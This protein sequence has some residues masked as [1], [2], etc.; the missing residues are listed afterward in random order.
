LAG[1]LL[2]LSA[3]PAVAQSAAAVREAIRQAAQDDGFGKQVL[4]LTGFAALP[5]VNASSFS[6]SNT[7]ASDVDVGRFAAS[8]SHR[9]EEVELLGGDL[10]VEGTLSW[11]TAETDYGV[12]FRGTAFEATP[13]NRIDAWTAIGGIG[14]AYDVAPGFTVT[15]V[16][17]LGWGMVQDDTE[18]SGPGA[19][20]LDRATDDLLFN[21]DAQEILYGPALRLEYLTALPGDVN[22]TATS[23]LNWVFGTTYSASNRVLEGDT[24]FGVMTLHGEL[25]GPTRHSAFGRELRWILF[26]AGTFIGGEGASAL[27]VDWIAE[28]G[29]GMEIVDREAAAGLGV[30]G[31]SLRLSV[32]TGDDIFGWSVGGGLEF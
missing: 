12:L 27:G 8:P 6:I 24:S 2:A 15:P 21:W 31:L 25:D 10:Y 7:G 20:R 14:V 16:A 32:L 29:V 19:A 18:F 4:G 22:V 9:F 1:A 30:E 11:F 3:A 26:G 17:T 5:G 23:R 13:K 28:F